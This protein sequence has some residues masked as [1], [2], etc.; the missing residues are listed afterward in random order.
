MARIGT[1]L[2]NRTV[3]SKFKGQIKIPRKSLEQLIT[4]G[5]G[6]YVFVEF[7]TSQLPRVEIKVEADDS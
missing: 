6:S 5:T 7:E 1:K 4:R 3:A 2:S